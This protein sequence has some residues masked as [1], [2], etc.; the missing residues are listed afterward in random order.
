VRYWTNKFE[1]AIAA[2]I[3]PNRFHQNRTVSWQMSIP[4]SNRRPS[5]FRSGSGSRTYISTTGRMTLGG[6]LTRLKECLALP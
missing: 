4:R 2:N 5:T 6:K 1:P 3:A